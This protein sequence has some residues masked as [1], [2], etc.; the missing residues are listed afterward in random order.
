M[1]ACNIYGIYNNKNYKK[2][3]KNH[4]GIKSNQIRNL[5]GDYM[6]TSKGV[7]EKDLRY[8]DKEWLENQ[9]INQKKSSLKIA[10]E[11]NVSKTTILKWLKIFEI[12]LRN[13]SE[14]HKGQEAWNKGIPRSEETKKKISVKAMGNKRFLGMNHSE[15]T[16]RKI[17]E[18]KKGSYPSEETRRK[19]SES[20]KGEKCHL[21]KGGISK[22]KGRFT[23][24]REWK[25]IRKAV[26]QRDNNI[27]QCC[28]NPI[29][30]SS[31]KHNLSFPNVHHIIGFKCRELRL[32][33]SNL[34]LLC[35]ECHLW[36]H[37]NRNKNK[38]FILEASKKNIQRI[39]LYNKKRT[40]LHY[41]YSLEV[42]V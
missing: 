37:S 32:I 5:R 8:R 15:E 34:I 40:I 29:I 27:C 31:N 12:P 2:I 41:I 42:N 22:E 24:S 19:M 25:K 28:D 13:N 17:S 7:Q 20:H 30:F 21:W 6:E 26:Y 38:K 16:K 11:C 3:S 35:R 1:Y 14:A 9:Y 4:K 36:V 39:L 18:K 23:A 33:L 10:K